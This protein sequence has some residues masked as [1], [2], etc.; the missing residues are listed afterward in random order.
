MNYSVLLFCSMC[1]NCFKTQQ[2]R[3]YV[4]APYYDCHTN[5]PMLDLIGYF[6]ERKEL[7]F[8]C[9]RGDFYFFIYMFVFTLFKGKTNQPSNVQPY[10]AGRYQLAKNSA[11]EA[12]NRTQLKTW[13]ACGACFGQRTTPATHKIIAM[14]AHI[15]RSRIAQ[16]ARGCISHHI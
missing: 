13:G 15:S 14:G 3:S 11:R 5:T 7:R 12:L 10:L 8:L 4:H 2:T 1:G 16:T 6:V 9:T